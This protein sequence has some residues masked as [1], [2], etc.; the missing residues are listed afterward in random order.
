MRECGR[1]LLFSLNGKPTS[2]LAAWATARADTAYLVVAQKLSEDNLRAGRR[3]RGNGFG[4]RHNV[5]MTG[6]ESR[7]RKLAH[8]VGLDRDVFRAAF[9]GASEAKVSADDADV[10]LL[11]LLN[12]RCICSSCDA[13]AEVNDCPLDELVGLA[14]KRFGMFSI[15]E[16][17]V[18]AVTGGGA[19]GRG[20][21]FSCRLAIV[22]GLW[23]KR[24]H[25]KKSHHT[26]K[27]FASLISG[28]SA[29]RRPPIDRG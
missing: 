28:V 4:C 11:N 9:G 23:G 15:C 27:Q 20:S 25:A 19:D 17:A 26:T 6:R 21:A 24:V 5:A 29:G 22:G 16:I 18:L 10:R 13:G 1:Y 3:R 8:P 14:G 12:D 7:P 2:A